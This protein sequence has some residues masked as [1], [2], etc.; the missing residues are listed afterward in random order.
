MLPLIDLAAAGLSSG[1]IASLRV[2]AADWRAS[3]DDTLQVNLDEPDAAPLVDCTRDLLSA[4]AEPDWQRRWLHE[5]HRLQGR[6]YSSADLLTALEQTADRTIERLTGNFAQAS[7]LELRLTISLR[8][9]VVAAVCAA[10]ELGEAARQ[11]E[12]GLAS[13]HAA[14]VVLNRLRQNDTPVTIFSLSLV[15]RDALSQLSAS[16]LQDLPMGIADR[17]YRCL[18]PQ[19]SIFAGREA[20]WITVLPGVTSKVQA[21]VT[22]TAIRQEFSRPLALPG[23][24]RMRLD[25]MIGIAMMPAD[26]EPAE[27]ALQAARLARHALP[28]HAGEPGWFHPALRD[29][30]SHRVELTKEL[31]QAIAQNQLTLHLQ[32][33]VLLPEARCIGAELLLRWQRAGGEWVPPPLIV[34]MIEKNGWRPRFT[35]W[36]VRQAVGISNDLAAAGIEVRLSL[37]LSADDLLDRDLPELFAQIL[38]TWQRPAR[39]LAV[40]LTESAALADRQCAQGILERL[41]ALGIEL[42]LDDFG[43]GYSSLG[44]LATL[45]IRELK[46]DRSFII[47]MENSPDQLRLVR[48]IIDLAHDLGMVPLAEGVESTTQRDR[49]LAL[50]CP[51]MQGYLYARPMP[52]ADFIPWFREHG[53]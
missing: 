33:Q 24:Q 31:E 2:L 13:E 1:D 4:I 44:H 17:L 18:R 9:A 50:G 27:L 14:L 34:D 39:L 49:L 53:R 16:D 25:I 6:G 48:S 45:P 10:I 37:N 12:T 22:A 20:E 19:D 32:P 15:N 7:R 11:A 3:V 43:T 46:I 51:R 5:W 29:D 47:A 52:L 30:W 42:A 21:A 40:E 26:G 35:D 23:G 8:R 36:L 41:E 38:A 28:P